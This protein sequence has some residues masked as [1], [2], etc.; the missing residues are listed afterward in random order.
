MPGDGWT[1]K[2]ASERFVRDLIDGKIIGGPVEVDKTS[3]PGTGRRFRPRDHHDL[4]G[5]DPLQALGAHR[6]D[7][8]I[9]RLWLRG[10]DYC[11]TG[12]RLPHPR[13]GI[14]ARYRA[15]RLCADWPLESIVL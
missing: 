1:E 10:H 3:G 9:V 6:R 11:S 5:T 14:G 13:G 2:L 8:W 12:R 7:A 15:G 4:L